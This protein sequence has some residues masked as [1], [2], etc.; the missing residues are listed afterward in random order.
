MLNIFSNR[1]LNLK[2]QGAL[3][4]TGENSKNKCPSKVSTVCDSLIMD[5][6]K[7]R[8]CKTSI[9]TKNVIAYALPYFICGQFWKNLK[10]LK[11]VQLH[12]DQLRYFNS[13]HYDP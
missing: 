7:V 4:Y 3:C 1:L 9:F 13:A 11:R 12:L 2:F 8:I 5:D 10:E 6:S